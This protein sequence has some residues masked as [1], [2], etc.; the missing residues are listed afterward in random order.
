MRFPV[1]A[2]SLALALVAASS[3]AR[4]G[5]P[6]S[7][8]T[9]GFR[10]P[11]DPKSGLYYEPADSADTGEWAASVWLSYQYRPI[12]LRSATTHDVVFDVVSHQ[13]MSDIAMG[14]G[15]AHRLTLG[16]DMPVLIYQNGDAPTPASVAVLGASGVPN[17]ALGDLAL[18]GKLTILRPSNGTAG[19]FGLALHQRFTLPTGDESSYLG[20]GAIT[21]ETR[22]LGEFDLI[23]ASVHAAAGLKFRAEQ[24]RFACSPAPTDG[25]DDPCRTRFGHEI[26]FGLGLAFRPQALGIDDKGKWTWFLETFG[27]LPM[28]PY[29]PFS[30]AALSSAHLALGA[31]YAA[32]RDVT[33]LAAVDT[34]LTSG[35]GESPIRGTLSVAWAPRVHDMDGDGVDDDADQCKE[36]PEDR[37][38]FQ[39][40]DGCRET[41]NDEDGV[42]D[43]QDK[44]PTAKE[45]E[46][47]F[48]DED[49]CP[50]PDNDKD[51]IPDVED[52]CPNEAGPRHPEDP[53]KD[54]CPIKDRDGDGIDDPQD[55]CPDQAEDKDGFEDADGCPDPDN[56]KDGIPDALDACPNVKGVA[57]EDPKENGCPDLDP[58]HDTILGAADKCPDQPETFNGFEDADGCPDTKGKPVAAMKEDAKKGPSLSVGKA[59]K[60]TDKDEVDP[61]SEA[62]LRAIAEELLRFPD[63]TLLVGVKPAKKGQEAQ[64][65]ARSEA[66]AKAIG[67]LARRS[68]VARAASFDEVKKDPNAFSNGVG[69]V[70]V[71]PNVVPD[72]GA[73]AKAKDAQPA[74]KDTKKETKKVAEPDIY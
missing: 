35:V 68:Q 32:F 55:K 69:F 31:R 43:E 73:P 9:R 61:S 47:G 13:L 11:Q 49:G 18:N 74:K 2:S 12:T 10:A 63:R 46:D 37:D 40:A 44:C 29:A 51:N 64:A 15:V 16:F 59:I 25:T 19:G 70:V 60:F 71:A 5:D 22:F 45:D 42:P 1:L 23:A 27:H 36:D 53:K 34:S 62:V 54:G 28:S 8:D 57:A 6:P 48:Q 7:L 38:G 41:D 26:P 17:Q 20:E 30:N 52:K 4:A 39:D 14:F 33:L 67:K 3:V 66:L 24:E 21:S 72:A 50:D 65:K 56:D 58:D